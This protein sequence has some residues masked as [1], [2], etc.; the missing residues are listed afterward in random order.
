[1]RTVLAPLA[2]LTLLAG[3]TSVPGVGPT[4]LEG[5]SWRFDR[6]DGRGAAGSAT[7]SFDA[8]RLSASAGCNRMSA[9]WRHDGPFI[10]LTGPLISTR[11]ACEGRMEDENAVSEMLQR[12]PEVVV[13]GERMRITSHGHR[14]ELRLRK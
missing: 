13:A 6:I 12:R 5:T 14:A 1:M 10:V 4:R 11:M 9:P 3:C 7:L 2:A 8:E